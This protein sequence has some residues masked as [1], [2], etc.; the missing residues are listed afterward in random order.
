MMK[1]IWLGLVFVIGS[2]ISALAQQTVWIQIE[3]N[4]TLAFSTEQVRAYSGLIENVKG[5]GL[6]G[7]WY[8]IAAGPYTPDEA[9]A[10]LARLRAAGLIPRD[11]YVSDG[12][13][14]VDQFWPVG[15]SSLLGADLASGDT[16]TEATE[17]A[18]LEIVGETEQGVEEVA[19]AIEE[20]EPVLEEAV[21][22]EIAE[23]IT[24][25]E[26][27][28]IL[29]PEPVEVPEETVAQARRS[30]GRLSRDEKKDLQIAL[31]WF[32]HYTAA[33]DGAYGPGTRRSMTSWQAANGLEETGVLTSSQRE[34]L[35]GQ[36]A[37]ALAVLGLRT[38]VDEVAG[39]EIEAPMGLVQFDRHEAPF[40]HYAARDGSGVRLVLISQPGDR[41]TMNGLYEI[42]QTLEDVPGEGDR[43]KSRDS[44][45]ITGVSADFTS[46]TRVELEDGHIHGFML[47]WP[48]EQA[49]NIGR[50]LPMMEASLKSVGAP[51]ALN[52][53]FDPS[54][55]SVDLVSGLTVRTPDY[56]RSGFFV[57]ARGRV[58]TT[59][60]VATGCARIT[61]DQLYDA[62]VVHADAE[63]GLAILEPVE[64]LAP[65]S[66][67]QFAQSEP[68]LRSRVSVAGFP[69]EGILGAATLTFGTLEDVRGLGGE[70]DVQRLSVVAQPGDLGGP[71]LDE[72]GAV[73]GLLLPQ[74]ADGRVLPADVALARKA[75][76]LTAILGAEGVSAT[77][78]TTAAPM[79]PEDL[80]LRAAEMTVLVSCWN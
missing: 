36:Y 78:A 59:S 5:F 48:P 52:Y 24:E 19:E 38:I 35:L 22:A 45:S 60:E 31:Q 67:A 42:L 16:E 64:R 4:R 74:P 53:G 8:A 2:T 32:G 43:S 30:E 25:E 29:A 39:I 7:N 66:V 15:E 62:E 80:T 75:E 65:M 27:V 44:F 63:M 46:E 21:V 77:T 11:A 68:R 54:Q 26:P 50:V 28:V 51:M 72:T 6:G 37:D 14:Y 49:G 17:G 79:A 23:E 20:A 58:L 41:G 18:T 57:D 47:I 70:T 33:I 56:S 73:T 71:V 3:A 10:E 34:T 1:Q 12:A 40:A 61:I 76:S 13:I 55:Q 9:N 69:F